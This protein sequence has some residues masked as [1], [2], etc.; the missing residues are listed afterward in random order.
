M[1]ATETIYEQP[2]TEMKSKLDLGYVDCMTLGKRR[3]NQIEDLGFENHCQ[4]NKET[5]KGKNKI[6]GVVGDAV[7]R[8][9]S[10]KTGTIVNMRASMM[11]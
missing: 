3:S 7:D 1:K 5:R 6:K 10:K 8:P 4:G 2:N 9:R 11:T